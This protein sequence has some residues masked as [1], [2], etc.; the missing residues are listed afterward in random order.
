MYANAKSCIKSG[1][2]I[3]EFF[4]CDR[5]VRQG[6]N[7]SPLLFAIYLNDFED[8]LSEFTLG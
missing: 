6:E 7:P 8:F 5:G 3:S 4:T 1:H 2:K